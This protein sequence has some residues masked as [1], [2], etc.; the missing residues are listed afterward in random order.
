MHV[1]LPQLRPDRQ[2][3]RLRKEGSA[4]VAVDKVSVADVADRFAWSIDYEMC[5]NMVVVEVIHSYGLL[6]QRQLAH[7]LRLH[8]LESC[9]PRSFLGSGLI[10]PSRGFLG[11]MGQLAIL[12]FVLCIRIRT[13]SGSEWHAIAVVRQLVITSL[14]LSI[15]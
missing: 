15:L 4:D 1:R 9:I 8:L 12:G 14:H 5:A 10:I 2:R 11:G 7:L 6:R 3:A 13:R